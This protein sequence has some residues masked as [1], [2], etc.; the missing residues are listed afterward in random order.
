M[1]NYRFRPVARGSRVF[2]KRETNQLYEIS[3]FQPRKTPYH[4]WAKRPLN[5]VFL[6]KLS[7]I[8]HDRIG[9]GTKTVHHRF[10]AANTRFEKRKPVRQV[11]MKYWNKISIEKFL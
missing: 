4:E 10:K 6:G 8:L 1:I 3:S 11:S 5:E 7:G 9:H 2:G